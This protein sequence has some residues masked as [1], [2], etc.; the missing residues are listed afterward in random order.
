[1]HGAHHWLRI[2]ARRYDPR[3][4]RGTGAL[5]TPLGRCAGGGVR[6]GRAIGSTT[7][8]GGFVDNPGWS[9]GRPVYSEDFAATIYSAMG[10]N[11]RTIRQ[12]DP[13]G[14]GFE[15]VATTGTNYVGEPIAEL[16]K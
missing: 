5:G 7:S 3:H 13:L 15:Y 10:I 16:F 2:F 11:Y 4:E 12:D 14:R 9:L 1:M 8:N 6:G